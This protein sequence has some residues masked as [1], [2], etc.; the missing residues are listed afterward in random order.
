MNTPSG[1]GRVSGSGSSA[2]S[3]A[4]SAIHCAAARADKGHT[5]EA[6]PAGLS[7]GWRFRRLSLGKS[8]ESTEDTEESAARPRPRPCVADTS[9]DS[10]PPLPAQAETAPETKIRWEQWPNFS[11]FALS[12]SSV[13]SAACGD[14]SSLSGLSDRSSDG[15]ERPQRDPLEVQA[16]ERFLAADLVRRVR[17]AQAEIPRLTIEEKITLPAWLSWGRG[18]ALQDTTAAGHVSSTAPATAVLSTQHGGTLL[19]T[20][21]SEHTAGVSPKPRGRM[22][23]VVRKISKR[24][25]NLRKMAAAALSA[26]ALWLDGVHRRPDSTFA[27]GSSGYPR[28][29]ASSAHSSLSPIQHTLPYKDRRKS[30][31]MNKPPTLSPLGDDAHSMT[32]ALE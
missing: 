30:H 11:A 14:V 3:A 8:I 6:R 9:V 24:L 16:T 13:Y 15:D 25:P 22:R 28:Q 21:T 31:P 4:R 2:C 12:S 18:S 26:P 23:R 7:L 1:H 19:A 29:L 5:R 27:S 10:P 20:A 17:N 32:L